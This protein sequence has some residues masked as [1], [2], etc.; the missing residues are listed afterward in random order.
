MVG[1]GWL[2]LISNHDWPV[3]IL[4]VCLLVNRSLWLVFGFYFLAYDG[5]WWFRTNGSSG[6]VDSE[7]LTMVKWWRML[8]QCVMMANWYMMWTT[9]DIAMYMFSCRF[10]D[11]S[12]PVQLPAFER[13]RQGAITGRWIVQL[14]LSVHGLLQTLRAF[15]MSTDKSRPTNN[16]RYGSPSNSGSQQGRQM[17]SKRVSTLGVIQQC[18]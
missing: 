18:V 6:M 14:S 16:R 15:M 3:T 5:L 13:A 8:S 12:R 4:M 2:F 10:L 1:N 11:P 9:A 7:W 17:S